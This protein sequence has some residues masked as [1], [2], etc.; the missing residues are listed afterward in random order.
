M[1]IFHKIDGFDKDSYELFIYDVDEV[2]LDEKYDPLLGIIIR[3]DPAN[4]TPPN[5]V[6]VGI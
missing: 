5:F 2:K 6:S 1:S 4:Y 3:N